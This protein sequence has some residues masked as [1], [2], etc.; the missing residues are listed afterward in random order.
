MAQSKQPVIKENLEAKM[1]AIEA[2][3]VAAKTNPFYLLVTSDGKNS[4][5]IA[6]T[7]VSLRNVCALEL[8]QDKLGWRTCSIVWLSPAADIKT[9]IQVLKRIPYKPH[10]ILAGKYNPAI[11]NCFEFNNDDQA[12]YDSLL[13]KHCVYYEAEELEPDTEP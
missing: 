8:S 6:I 3:M 12:H 4:P 7:H 11:Y 5:Y 1:Q 2:A 13:K 10:H 9:V